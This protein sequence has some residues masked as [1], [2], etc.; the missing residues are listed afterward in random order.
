MIS[1]I[2]Y[3][4][5]RA[6]LGRW[7]DTQN[8]TIYGHATQKTRKILDSERTTFHRRLA[9]V[10]DT[11]QQEINALINL[12]ESLVTDKKGRS[13]VLTKEVVS[14]YTQELQD[15]FKDLELHRRLLVGKEEEE[16]ELEDG[17]IEDQEEGK[18]ND[19]GEE[20]I[21]QKLSE[22]LRSGQRTWKVLTEG[23]EALENCFDSAQTNFYFEIFTCVED[24]SKARLRLASENLEL[25]EDQETHES[26]LPIVSEKLSTTGKSLE[27]QSEMLA[28]LL[29]EAA[30]LEKEITAVR[31][32]TV[33]AN[34]VCQLVCNSSRCLKFLFTM[35]VSG[36]SA[37]WR[38]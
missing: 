2:E 7:K 9:D 22:L 26:E 16:E 8:S 12:P 11:F 28:K 35:F 31:Q 18:I 3:Q 33:E 1:Y 10:E 19:S 32:Q 5:A 29:S 30:E 6:D 15:W 4:E 21:G 38:F 23:I 37:F 24:D 14:Q 34:S 27:K 25:L 17:E 36:R 13:N 20:D